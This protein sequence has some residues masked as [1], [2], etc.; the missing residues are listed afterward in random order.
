MK[1]RVVYDTSAQMTGA[2]LNECLNPGPKFDQK[3]LDILTRFRVHRV[4][5]TADV[6]K[7]FLMISV[8]DKDREFLRFLWVEDPVQEEPRVLCTDLPVWSSE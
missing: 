6:E 3:I 7:A 1:L 8:A 2:S 5:V 4:A